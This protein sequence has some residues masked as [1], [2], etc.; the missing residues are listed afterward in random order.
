MYEYTVYISVTGAF[1]LLSGC[2]VFA[3]SDC[4]DFFCNNKT[5]KTYINP[6][7]NT[8]NEQD[9]TNELIVTQP[10]AYSTI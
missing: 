7:D 10:P 6:S 9:D 4:T 1:C 3:C 2:V 5:K 8:M